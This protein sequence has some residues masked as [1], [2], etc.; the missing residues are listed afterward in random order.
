MNVA[1]HLHDLLVREIA[2]EPPYRLDP[3]AALAG[4]RRRRRNRTVAL[5]AAAGATGVVALSAVLALQPHRTNVQQTL[6]GAAPSATSATEPQSEFERILRAHT[7]SSWTI[8][9]T[10][11]LQSDGFQADVDDGDGASRLYFGV[12]PSPGSLQQHPC[13][14]REFALDSVC[15]EVDLDADTRL[16]TRGPAK[17]GP[18][19]SAH[20]VIVHR[21]GSGVNV[22]NDNA[23]WP[24]TGTEITSPMTQEQKRAMTIGRVNRPLPVYSMAQLVEIAKA[25]DASR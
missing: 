22:G 18:V 14:D 17:S 19:T 21:D 6:F 23:T 9:E 20:V 13:S 1:E 15:K 7:P 5:T 3:D 11:R 2:D 10:Q 12:S 4:G 24:W 8:S 25:V 16:I